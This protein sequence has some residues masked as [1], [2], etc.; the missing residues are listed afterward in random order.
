[1]DTDDEKPGLPRW[2]T[3]GVGPLAIGMTASAAAA[4]MVAVKWPGPPADGYGTL[5]LI[6]VIANV[7]AIDNASDLQGRRDGFRT[8]LAVG[9]L[10]LTL[11]T[12]IVLYFR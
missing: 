9:S 2:W 11:A 8:W 12:L 4:I 5:V 10:V 7:A 3:S 1:M 6:S